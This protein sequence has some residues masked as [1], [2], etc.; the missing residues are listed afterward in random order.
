MV[1]YMI[2]KSYRYGLFPFHPLRSR[3]ARLTKQTHQQILAYITVMRIRYRKRN[4]TLHHIWMLA[5]L[6]W[7]APAELPHAGDKDPQGN[8]RESRHMSFAVLF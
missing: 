5:L 3:D 4:G 8:R 1:I 7:A 6:I 2:A